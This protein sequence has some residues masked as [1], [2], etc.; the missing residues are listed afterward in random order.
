M[1]KKRVRRLRRDTHL[2]C[3]GIDEYHHTFGCEI[4]E[5]AVLEGSNPIIDHRIQPA[6]Q[7]GSQTLKFSLI[8]GQL[9]PQ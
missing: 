2:A 8:G 5:K 7:T 6:V 1:I 4:D 3:E 9:A